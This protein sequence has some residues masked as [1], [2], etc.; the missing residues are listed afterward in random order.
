MWYK[1]C[2]REYNGSLFGS[3]LLATESAAKPTSAWQSLQSR[4]ILWQNSTYPWVLGLAQK[5]HARLKHKAFVPI[6]PIVCY[7]SG[8]PL[9]ALADGR[10]DENQIFNLFYGDEKAPLVSMDCLLAVTSIYLLTDEMPLS[11]SI[12]FL[13]LTEHGAPYDERCAKKLERCH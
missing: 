4:Q 13:H 3:R 10:F 8:T 6:I 12:S 5:N 2:S 1:S 7:L 9:K 11:L